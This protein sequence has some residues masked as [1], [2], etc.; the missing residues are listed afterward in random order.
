M[1]DGRAASHFEW[2]LLAMDELG[3]DTRAVRATVRELVAG[4]G[5]AEAAARA[6]LPAPAVEFT[7]ETERAL[8]A[9][10][11]VRVAVF[12]HGR[13]EVIPEMFLPIV[14]RLAESGVP[15][16]HLRSYLERHIEV[17]GEDHGPLAA[18][19]L[20]E[21]LGGSAERRAEADRAAVRALAA[22]ER[23]W[24]AVADAIDGSD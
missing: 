13:E 2:Y 15:C 24:S 4:H 23:L 17:D 5:L 7:A 18:R 8:A 12:L 1:P 14:E 6:G 21:V 22:R 11:H 9:P 20:E 16:D 3:A 19:L 10:L